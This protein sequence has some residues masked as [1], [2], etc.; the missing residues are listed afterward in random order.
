MYDPNLSIAYHGQQSIR[1]VFRQFRRYGSGKVK[2]L[3]KHP[4]SVRARHFAAPAL[5][6]WSVAATAVALRRPKLGAAAVAPY[7]G[8]VAAVSLANA[9]KLDDGADR[10]RLP[11]AFAAMHVGWGLGFWEGVIRLVRGRRPGSPAGR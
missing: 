10:V 4:E 5:V 3:A 1:G 6:A 7:L 2:V 8:A 9:R 11:L